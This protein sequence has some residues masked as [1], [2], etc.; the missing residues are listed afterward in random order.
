MVYERLHVLIIDDDAVDRMQVRLAFKGMGITCT[1]AEDCTSALLLLKRQ[2]FDCVFIDYLLPDGDGLS[3][4][5]EIRALGFVHPLIILTGQGDEEKAVQFMKAGASDYMTKAN[6]S[7]D[8]LSQVL[9]S[10]MR[11]YQA[12]EATRQAIQNLRDS[13]ERY[14]LVIEGSNDG[15]WDWDFRTDNIFLSDRFLEIIGLT[16][17]SFSGRLKD[18]YRL[19]IAEDRQRVRKVFKLHF[20]YR[21][22]C[23]TEFRLRRSDGQIR[24]CLCRG[25]SLYNAKDQLIRMT[26]ILSD[27]SERKWYESEREQLLENERLAR[28]EAE[29]ANRMKDEFLATV[30]HELRTP[31]NAIQGWTQLLQQG[32]LAGAAVH[33][34]LETIERS[35]HMQNQLIED[36]LDVSRIVA[37]KMRLQVASISLGHVIEQALESVGPAAAAKN[38]ALICQLQSSHPP[39]VGDANRLQQVVW[40]LLSNAIKF[41]PAG[42]EVIVRLHFTADSA[43]VIVKDNGQGIPSE[44]LPLVFERFRQL[45]S[46]KTRQYGGLGL[47][48][49]IVRHLTELHGGTAQVASDGIGKGAMFTIHLPLPQS[50]FANSMS[51][52][53]ELQEKE[54]R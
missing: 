10:A 46:T 13:E 49:A 40:N 39:M 23:A 9:R 11:V 42:G 54:S 17:L 7:P 33:R 37:G 50:E 18:F 24:Y 5:T 45:D 1:E 44:F 21:V 38:I 20:K 36:L 30:S 2:S 6:V 14:R 27:I 48:L 52:G 35:A 53:E 34:A 31:L 51:S 25:R 19:I 12:E 8:S 15:I 16:N 41:T 29:N 47:G 4:V 26:G 28:Q 43:V 32:R 3:L 22:E